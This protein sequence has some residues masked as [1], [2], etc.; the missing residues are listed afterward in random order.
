MN[1]SISEFLSKP[2]G[3]AIG[4]LVV[5]LFIFVLLRPKNPNT[6]YTIAGV[7][8]VIFILANSVMIFFAENTWS[9]FFISLLFSLLYLFAV[10]LLTST[11]IRIARADGSGE[12]AMIFLVIIYHPFVLLLAILVKWVIS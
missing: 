8:Y 9:Y 10:E 4:F 1:F 11:Y 5:M 3:L 2:Y 6:L 12:S 7:L